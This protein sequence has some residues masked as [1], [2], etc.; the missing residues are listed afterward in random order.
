MQS[1][2]VAGLIAQDGEPLELAGKARA[3]SAP[4]VP[5]VLGLTDFAATAIGDVRRT[6]SGREQCAGEREG[7]G[8]IE[9]LDLELRAGAPGGI[10]LEEANRRLSPRIEVRDAQHE[11]APAH[12]LHALEDGGLV[13][14]ARP[15]QAEPVMRMP[16]A[17]VLEREALEEKPPAGL[18]VVGVLIEGRR[19]VFG[20]S[21]RPGRDADHRSAGVGAIAEEVAAGLQPR[22]GRDETGDSIEL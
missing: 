20:G 21:P 4:L 8:A 16:L 12:R 15:L 19:V 10:E 2:S 7:R 3:H 14:C 22:I 5:G 9:Y 17:D 11:A 13:A 18:E 1:E 6:L